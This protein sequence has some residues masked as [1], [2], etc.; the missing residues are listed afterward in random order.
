MC[1]K[2]SIN[3]KKIL[4]GYIFVKCN[5]SSS[6]TIAANVRLNEVGPQAQ[7]AV[8]HPGAH[9]NSSFPCA[10]RKKCAEAEE[11]SDDAFNRLLGDVFL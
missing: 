6:C 4:L 10:I 8:A 1:F 2:K 3:S 9:L 7:F 5:F 11:R